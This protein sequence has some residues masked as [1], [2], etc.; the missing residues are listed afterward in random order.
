MTIRRY[1]LLSEAEIELWRSVA[2]TVVARPGRSLSALSPPQPIAS[3]PS[4]GTPA[5]QKRSK[6]VVPSYLPPLSRPKPALPPLAPIERQYR[7]KV[8]R[9]RIGIERAIDLHGFNQ[10]EA[11]VAL[12]SFIRAAQTEGL[13]LV[14]IVTG[15]GGRGH[16]GA[17]GGVLRRAVPHWLA[18]GD[19]RTIV[20]GFEEA[21][22]PHGGAGALYVRLRQRRES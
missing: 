2:E 21:G 18:E 16:S 20:L 22:L 11:H 15:K 1:R 6:A 4:G 19:L 17:E 8:T 10:A 5:A 12:R 7:R 9:G 3:P 14:L 13:R